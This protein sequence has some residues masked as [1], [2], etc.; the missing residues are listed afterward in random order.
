MTD[1]NEVVAPGSEGAVGGHPPS[2]SVSW[3]EVFQFIE[4]WSSRQELHLDVHDDLLIPGTPQ[5][6]SLP[7]EDA[8]K[9]L[10][11]I[12]GGIRE[13]LQHDTDQ[14]HRAEA[15]RAVAESADWSTLARRVQ[16]GRGDAY[17]PR[18]AS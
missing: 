8:R 7:D 15:A 2:R 10:A 6:C 4:R 17:V 3:F 11:V 9:L 13:A 5:W 1:S 14:E 16:A 18:K 12:L